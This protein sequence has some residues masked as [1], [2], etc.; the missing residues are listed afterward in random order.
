M[1]IEEFEQRQ[2]KLEHARTELKKRF[3]GI[4]HIVDDVITRIS[5]WYI[6]PDLNTRPAIICLWGMTGVGKTDL[7]RNLVSL[8]DLGD[9]FHEIQLSGSSK[10]YESTIASALRYSKLRPNMQG[11]LL[12]DEIQRY[13]TVNENGTEKN[14]YDYSDLWMLLSDGKLPTSSSFEDVVDLLFD[15]EEKEKAQIAE[16]MNKKPK[17]KKGKKDGELTPADAD[18]DE[19]SPKE[20]N[21]SRWRAKSLK[22]DLNLEESVEQIMNWTAADVRAKV[23]EFA[24]RDSLV[25]NYDNYSKLLIVISGNLDEAFTEAFNVEDA[26][27]DADMMHELT[28]RINM[29]HIKSALLERFK[30]EQI[31][32]FGNNH[33]LYPTLP[34]YAFERIIERSLDTY[35]K[36]L[37]E[38]TGVEVTIYGNEIAQMLYNNSVFPSQGTRP[39]FSTISDFINVC[40][41]P[42]V[43]RA[44][45][46]GA[47]RIDLFY[48]NERVISDRGDSIFYKAPLDEIRKTSAV[49]KNLQTIVAVHEAGHAMVQMAVFGRA[50]FQIKLHNDGTG[51]NW[52]CAAGE[53]FEAKLGAVQVLYGGQAAENVI[54]GPD[55][56]SCGAARDISEATT[57]LTTLIRR[58]GSLDSKTVV[59]GEANGDAEMFDINIHET[60]KQLRTAAATQ[61]DRARRIILTYKDEVKELAKMLLEHR[62]LTTQ[63]L[64]EFGAKVLDKPI[65]TT[66]SEEIN[67]CLYTTDYTAILNKKE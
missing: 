51:A 6:F 34:R 63:Q 18:E 10:T 3:F 55:L 43:L 47:T 52:L 8:L 50:P 60:N 35:V 22:Q 7:V 57:I 29:L 11:V 2:Q 27:T 64:A 32:R 25:R 9:Q 17:R 31:A 19:T 44:L 14:E 67:E 20:T 62:I 26:D 36:F 49:D 4:D 40:F 53:T 61:F 41:P 21:V 66:S 42:I 15:L 33:I 12:L 24:T 39:V 54:F 45:K 5:S 38:K 48:E 16:A 58:C 46:D 1:N 23:I 56:S 13:R 65:R 37:K 28:K 30:P 59:V